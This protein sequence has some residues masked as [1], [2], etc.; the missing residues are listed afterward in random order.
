MRLGSFFLL[1]TLMIMMI[2]GAPAAIGTISNPKVSP[3]DEA[4]VRRAYMILSTLNRL[5]RYETAYSL[6]QSLDEMKKSDSISFRLKPLRS[7]PIDEILNEQLYKLVTPR[8]GAVLQVARVTH[9]HNDDPVKFVSYNAF[10]KDEPQP[11]SDARTVY[12]LLGSTINA[13]KYDRYLSYEVTVMDRGKVRTYQAMAFFGGSVEEGMTGRIN[14][15]DGIIEGYSLGLALAEDGLPLHVPFSKFI[16]TQQYRD[17]V[18]KVKRGQSFNSP[19]LKNLVRPVSFSRL[20]NPG[21]PQYNCPPGYMPDPTYGCCDYATLKCCFPSDW[22]GICGSNSYDAYCPCSSGG[23]EG[24]RTR[25]PSDPAT[26]TKWDE[27]ADPVYDDWGGLEFHDISR[28]GN[29]HSGWMKSQGHCLH[30]SNCQ[31]YAEVKEYGFPP[32]DKFDSQ[33]TTDGRCHVIGVAIDQKTCTAGKGGQCT[34]S[35]AIGFAVRACP[36][37]TC[38]VST[39]ISYSGAGWSVAAADSFF[40]V[41]LHNDMV[42]VGD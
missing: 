39:S 17:L 7:G 26:C 38:S 35:R 29:Q 13:A 6:T 16:E 14:I 32:Y 1:V 3:R 31:T 28:Q 23:G 36:D 11:P 24:G 21:S 37:C 8:G 22:T 2:V 4:V 19:Q 33:H 41:V 18:D 27:W 42:C 10:W 40:S 9:H 20:A 5:D 25:D 34:A 12:E 30:K 15:I